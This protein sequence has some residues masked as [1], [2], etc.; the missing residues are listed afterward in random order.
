MFKDKDGNLVADNAQ[1]VDENG[2]KYPHDFPK[3]EIE[4]L[5]RVADDPE[6]EKN[7]REESRVVLMGWDDVR[8]KRNNLLMMCDWT[9]LPDNALP[10]EEKKK[11]TTY[12]QALR[13]LP[14]SC[15]KAEDVTWPKM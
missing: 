11:W 13:D 5:E 8:N 15:E 7:E 9:Q 14:S 1:Y 12:R 6:P 2:T 3:N 10:D 4:G